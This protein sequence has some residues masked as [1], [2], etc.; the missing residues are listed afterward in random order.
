MLLMF[1]AP[2]T[3]VDAAHATQPVPAH[4]VEDLAGRIADHPD[5]ELAQYLIDEPDSSPLHG[6][7]IERGTLSLRKHE[8]QLRLCA[9]YVVT[10][11]LTVVQVDA[12]RQ[13]TSG[14]FSDGA[15]EGWMQQLWHLHE[16]R[17]VVDWDAIARVPPPG[18]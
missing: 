16:M 7:P 12:L 11:E 6:A 15:G 5:D 2:V 17:L 10:L 1:C 9:T 13:Y 8:G 18:G 14:H 3:T 4:V